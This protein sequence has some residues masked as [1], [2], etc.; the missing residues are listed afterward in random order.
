MKKTG[1]GTGLDYTDGDGKTLIKHGF[2]YS[3]WKQ[4]LGPTRHPAIKRI[5]LSSNPIEG[6]G[7]NG[8]GRCIGQEKHQI[9]IESPPDDGKYDLFLLFHSD[10]QHFIIDDVTYDNNSQQYCSLE[11]STAT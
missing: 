6:H 11:I 3:R 1:S 2:C 7:D 5:S 10:V 8:S 4:D 9:S